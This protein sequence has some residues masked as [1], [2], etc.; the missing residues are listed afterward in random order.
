[1]NLRFPP[2]IWAIILNIAMQDDVHTLVSTSITSRFLRHMTL[3]I[4]Y[5]VLSARLYVPKLHSSNINDQ[6]QFRESAVA[7]GNM[8]QRCGAFEAVAEHVREYVLDIDFDW[9]KLDVS[10][11]DGYP[12]TSNPV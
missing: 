11:S 10:E 1:M 3:P 5:R 2:E 8:L 12:A 9:G 6:N 7:T 4:L